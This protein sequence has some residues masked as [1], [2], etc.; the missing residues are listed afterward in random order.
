MSIAETR[1]K[2]EEILRPLLEIRAAFLVDVQVRSE[3]GGKLVQAFVD[4]D[5]GIKV[6]LCA[7][8]SRELVRMLNLH[9]IFQGSFT[10]EVSSPGL[11][12]PLRLL[13]QYRKNIGRKFNVRYRSN[14]EVVAFTG[15]LAALNGDQLLF[16]PDSGEPVTITFSQIVESKEELPW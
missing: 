9:E 1:Q 15:T 11:E 6:E 16:N 12:K 13:R 8:I 4:T 14:G 7:E 2:I 3:R 5:E 10:V